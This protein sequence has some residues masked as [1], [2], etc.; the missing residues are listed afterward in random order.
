[1]KITPA[2]TAEDIKRCYK[3]M[4]QL[5]P[6]LMDVITF[7]EQVQRQIKDGYHLVCVE[8]NGEV[9]AL[10]GFRFLEFL[11]W[12]K[13][14]Y[15]DDLVTCSGARG[16]G[17]GGAIIKWLTQLAIERDCDQLHLDSGPQRHDAHKLYMKHKMKIIGHHFS[18]DL[19]ENS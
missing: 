16:L 17:H 13:V 4:H 2:E 11:A 18:L 1:M 5:R 3:V 8:E 7:V 19:R 14:L 6:H 9:R 12:G 15:I 10:A